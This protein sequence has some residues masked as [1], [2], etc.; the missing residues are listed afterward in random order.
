M[1]TIP[2]IMYSHCHA[3]MSAEVLVV[4]GVC[5]VPVKLQWVPL[6]AESA[7]LTHAVQVVALVSCP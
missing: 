2:I 6:V 3:E 7:S 5:W 1:D 4:R